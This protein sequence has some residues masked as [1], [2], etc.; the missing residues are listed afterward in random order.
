[1]LSIPFL[2]PL[3]YK[4]NG[5]S[6]NF[7][8]KY[9]DLFHY[10]ETIRD[11]EVLADYKQPFLLSD[12]LVQYFVSTVDSATINYYKCDGTPVHSV[13][14]T[15]AFTFTL[16]SDPLF[17]YSVYT[18]TTD[19]NDL[20]EGVFYARITDGLTT[21][22]SELFEVASSQPGTVL[23]KYRHSKGYQDVIFEKLAS[24]FYFYVR[25]Q[26]YVKHNLPERVSTT[27]EDQVLNMTPLRNIPYNSWAY[28]TDST[29]IPNYMI[30]ILNRVFGCFTLYID[31]RAFT[32]PQD[33]KWEEKEEEFYPL[34][35]WGI[36]MREKSLSASLNS[37]TDTG[38][39]TPVL[40]ASKKELFSDWW[41]TTSADDKLTGTAASG[42]FGYTI[43]QID[44]IKFLARD[45]RQ[46]DAVTSSPTNRQFYHN[47]GTNEVSFDT[48]LPFNPGETITIVFTKK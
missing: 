15:A 37:I 26:G 23:I 2:N 44:E 8:T 29:G 10:P 1:M 35:G 31:G 45:G 5:Y 27:Y 43:S 7:N 24:D 17:A 18:D 30:D 14:L 12:P 48:T 9:F 32:V 25:V 41:T 39:D 38:G 34:R 42:V 46:Y 20:G 21:F 3:R 33:A 13:S 40:P 19:L 6:N 28:I 11:F 36:D 22:E 47:T 16:P 4:E